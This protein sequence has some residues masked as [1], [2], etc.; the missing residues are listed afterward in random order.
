LPPGHPERI[1][2]DKVLNRVAAVIRGFLS[3]QKVRKI[4]FINRVIGKKAYQI[5]RDELMTVP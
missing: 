2:L 3:R 1:A 4:R 5:T